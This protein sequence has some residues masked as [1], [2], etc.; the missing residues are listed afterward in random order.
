MQKEG[1]R[2]DKN[3]EMITGRSTEKEENKM[4]KRDELALAPDANSVINI[5]MDTLCTD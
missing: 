3:D 1:E 5:I 4:I 2:G